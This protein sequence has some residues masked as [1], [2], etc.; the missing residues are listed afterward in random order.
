M[1]R[2]YRAESEGIDVSRK[3][4]V[5]ILA[6]GGSCVLIAALATFV[7]K[8]WRFHPWLPVIYGVIVIPTVFPP[9]FRWTRK[10]AEKYAGLARGIR[11]GL[12]IWTVFWV[13]YVVLTATGRFG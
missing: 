10:L 11:I 9:V 2:E 3:D 1:R 13:A 4:L 6:G 12:G 8:E 7:V 5:R